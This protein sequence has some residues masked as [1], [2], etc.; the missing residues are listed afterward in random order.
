MVIRSTRVVLADGVRAA[1]IH[2]EN[3][4][5]ARIDDDR[6]NRG[7]LFDAGDLVILPGLVD[8]HVHVNEPGR[9]EWEGFDTATRAAA[10]GGVTTIVDMPLN[11]V[12]ATTT[13]AAL[14]E[15]RSAARGRCHVNV[16]FW[17]GVVP[18]NASQL[19]P[20]VDAGVRGF[21]CFLVP[22][23]VDE[24]QH[25]GEPELREAMPV[26]AGR[27]VPL[28]VHAE[29]PETIL[30]PTRSTYEAYLASRPPEAEVEAIRM[31]IRLAREFGTRT[32]IVHVAC[33]EAVEEISRA[34]L[35]RVPITAETCPHYLTFA[36]E[37]I[38]EGA[39]EFKC[40]PPIRHSHHRE[41]LWSGLHSGALD[42]VA[43]DHSPAPPA[44][45]CRGDFVRAWGG[46]ASLEM[47]LAAVWTRSAESLA[48]HHTE[49]ALHDTAAA[50]HDTA[51]AL[52]DTA[53]ALH[54]TA[55]ARAFQAS[56]CKITRWMCAAPARLAGLSRKGRIAAG[57][58][59][60]L[61]VFDPDAEWI[62]D[63]ARLQQRHKLT[64][65]A[66]RRLRGAVRTTFL[67]GVRVWDDGRLV[68]EGAGR[69]E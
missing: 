56:V 64:P 7:D 44:L 35:D 66:G 16:A 37:E 11:S 41:A 15:K 43:T 5:I 61:L 6:S 58:D 52:H 27:G 18:G 63:P 30:P 62:V 21:K 68:R 45:K 33:A 9:T 50:L 20:L 23:G 39:T 2:V 60:D 19:E 25:V 59:A 4:V 17:G 14:D 46:I 24:F 57:C 32:H 1:S 42:L 34:K 12:P 69:L 40:A 31:I 54:D 36:G 22:S 26:L 10:A 29:S 47:S 48:L 28:L 67:R 38:A 53:V 8:T 51:V 65:Y 3:G 13:V 55:V 49:V